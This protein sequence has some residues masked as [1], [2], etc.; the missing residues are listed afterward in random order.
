MGHSRQR[1]NRIDWSRQIN[2]LHGTPCL[3]PPTDDVAAQIQALQAA[4]GLAS[5]TWYEIHQAQAAYS[6]L[7]AVI[8]LLKDQ[9][10]MLHSSL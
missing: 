4:L 9:A 7:Q 10:K 6:S 2:W 8:Q 3:T 1:T 5:I